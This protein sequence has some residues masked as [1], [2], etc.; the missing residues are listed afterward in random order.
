M[1]VV[2]RHH[3]FIIK[4]HHPTEYNGGDGA[5]GAVASGFVSANVPTNP[6]PTDC[7]RESRAV[8]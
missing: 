2:P 6:R 4:D 5:K 1:A 3:R 8:G 7:D